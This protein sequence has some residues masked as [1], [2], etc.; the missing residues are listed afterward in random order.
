[1]SAKP[2]LPADDRITVEIDGQPYTPRARA[3]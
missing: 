3:R 2:E 1:M